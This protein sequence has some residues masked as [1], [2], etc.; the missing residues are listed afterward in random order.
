MK[1]SIF[2]VTLQ[3]LLLNFTINDFTNKYMSVKI[4]TSIIEEEYDMPRLITDSCIACGSCIAECPVGA[5]A[6]GDIYVVDASLCI[7]CGACDAS[8][9]TGAI[10]EE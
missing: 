5:I 8:C 10:V 4:N 1:Y 3:I 2:I 6:E 9:P 7:D